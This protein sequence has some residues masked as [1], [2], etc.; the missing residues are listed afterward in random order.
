MSKSISCPVI[1]TSAS[2]RVDGS[3]GLR[4][5]TP[6]LSAT[7]KAAFFEILNQS[8]NMV[9][10]PTD[11]E[12]TLTKE[13][14]GQFDTKT[15]SQRLRAVLFVLWK[16]AIDDGDFDGFYKKQMEI[17]INRYKDKLPKEEQ[18]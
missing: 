10:M 8:M 18:A 15:P 17:I 1:L 9:L 3:I 5:A 12:P 7:D 11:S 14:K 4:F 2:T 13:V 6:E 16:G